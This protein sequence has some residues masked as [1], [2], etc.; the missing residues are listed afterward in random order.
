MNRSFS[1]KGIV[2]SLTG[3]ILVQGILLGLWLRR[4]TPPPTWDPAVHLMSA[5]RYREAVREGH[6]SILL[7]TKTSPGHP[8]YPPVVHGAMAVGMSLAKPLGISPEHGAIFSQLFFLALLAVGSYWLVSA[9]WGSGAGLAGAA[10]VTFAPPIQA[11]AHQALVDLGLTAFVV[12]AYAAWVK[13]EGFSRFRWSLT[14]GV[15]VGLGFLTKWTFPTYILPIAGSAAVRLIKRN[16]ARH[17][18]LAMGVAVALSAPWYLFNLPIL[19]PKLS[20]VA[21]LG[22]QEG[23]PSGTSWSGWFYYARLIWSTW[24][25]PLI[26]GGIAGLS[27]AIFRRAKSVVVLVPWFLSTYAVWSLVSN[28][29]PRYVM[30]AVVVLPMAFAALPF[31]LPALGALVAGVWATVAIFV[32]PGH[33]WMDSPMSGV[34][35]LEEMVQKAES[36][37]GVEAAPVSVLT[38]VSNHAFLNGNNLTWTAQKWGVSS[39]V[40]VRTKLDPLGQLTDFVLV[41]TGDLGPPRSIARQQEARTEIFS[42]KGWF[43]RSFVEAGRWSLPDGSEAVLFQRRIGS[44]SALSSLSP[45]LLQALLPHSVWTN[46]KTSIRQDSGD[47]GDV[48]ADV[49]A[50]ELR[51]REFSLKNVHLSLE[52][53]GLALDEDGTPRLIH[54][55]RLVVRSAEWTEEGLRVF[56]AKKVP[57]VKEWRVAFLEGNGLRANGALG[58]VP[59]RI[60][61]GFSLAADPKGTPRV[62]VDLR[63]IYLG[64]ISFPWGKPRSFVHRDMV[65]SPSGKM[66]FELRLAGLQTHSGRLEIG[67]EKP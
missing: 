58:P 33:R 59:I 20:R 10:L 5:W 40:A 67:E 46:F 29:D 3:L 36:L 1:S 44:G 66:P 13:S 42:E 37:R 43:G 45:D 25:G 2:V 54:L 57:Q 47:R 53:A 56:L 14:L 55:R 6:L 64:G 51:W 48:F 4:D 62:G 49:S 34:W 22:A 11:M 23:D 31:R 24:S 61:M 50:D 38:L 52:G 26:L 19:I 27:L 7:Q 9:F 18:F 60:E 63:Q 41:K 65:L 16:H 12:L 32:S 15:V 8:P 28:K 35:P 17:I 30:P 39:H 21:G